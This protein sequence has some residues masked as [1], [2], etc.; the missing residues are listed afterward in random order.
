MALAKNINVLRKDQLRHGAISETSKVLKLLKKETPTVA[1]IYQG[2]HITL[3]EV[4]GAIEVKEVNENFSAYIAG[5]LVQ[6]FQGLYDS[7][8]AKLANA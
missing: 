7:L 2:T 5:Q 8:K 1:V 4:N 6:H 3:T